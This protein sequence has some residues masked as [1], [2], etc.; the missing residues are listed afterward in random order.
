MSST[1]TSS[2]GA[3]AKDAGTAVKNVFAGIHGAGEKLRGEFNAG[4]DRAFD[5]VRCVF[6]IFLSRFRSH[7]AVLQRGGVEGL[8]FG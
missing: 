7:S 5:S 3:S 1:N 2:T 8:Y 4:V 6:S